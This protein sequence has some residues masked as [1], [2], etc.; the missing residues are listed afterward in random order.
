MIVIKIGFAADSEYK[1]ITSI[2]SSGHSQR[3]NKI[4]CAAV[5][6]LE[7]TFL[8]SVK[9]TTTAEVDVVIKKEAGEFF[10]HLTFLDLKDKKVYSY[11]CTFYLI[12]MEMI[13]KDN[14]QAIKLLK[15]K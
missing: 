14:P 13:A 15:L 3:D 1:E 10:Y 11:L 12:G 9:H 2:H 5:S 8:Q 4:L 7:Y 6:A